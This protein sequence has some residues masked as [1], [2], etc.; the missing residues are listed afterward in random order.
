MFLAR[1][2]L[3]ALE[4]RALQVVVVVVV[5]EFVVVGVL[6]VVG[7]VEVSGM[8]W[9][10]ESSAALLVRGKVVVV[11]V[12]EVV[13]VEGVEAAVLGCGV[14]LGGEATLQL[15]VGGGG[16]DER[17]ETECGLLVRVLRRQCGRVADVPANSKKY[18]LGLGLGGEY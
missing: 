10:E 13:E 2:G 14:A 6:V 17:D 7:A 16:V 9:A 11:V 4:A 18:V 12:V 1:L 15:D 3:L 8:N 5:V